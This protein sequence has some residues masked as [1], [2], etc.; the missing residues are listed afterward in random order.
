MARK[1]AIGLTV[2]ALVSG[3]ATYIAFTG[4]SP[5]GPNPQLVFIL[6]NLDLVLLLLLGAVVA[7][8]IVNLWVERRR[9]QAGSRLHIRLV[10]LFSIVAVTPAI[11]VAVFSA[12]FFNFGIQAWF[13]ERVRVALHESL[14]VTDAYLEEHTQTIRAD[15]LAMAN[16]INRDAPLLTRSTLIFQ[17]MVEEQAAARSMAEAIVF[18]GTGR[19]LASAGLSLALQLEPVP[20]FAMD[21]AR[22]GEVAIITSQDETRVRALVRLDRFFDTFLY[23]GRFI[24]PGVIAHVKRTQAAVAEY[25]RLEGQRSG[26]QISFFLLFAVVALLLL[27]A[28]VWV[29]LL[30]ANK[31]IGPIG[32]LI[33]AAERVGAGDLSARVNEIDTEDEIGG[34]SR[35]FN[36]MTA[37]LER[38]SQELVEANRQLDARRKFTETV[39]AGV[40]AGVIGL[41]AKGRINLPNRSAAELL[42]T[43]LETKIGQKLATAV[44]EM[45]DLLKRARR[46]PDRLHEAEVHLI[47]QGRTRTL[48]VRIAAERMGGEIIGFVVTFDDITELQS[49]QR[50]AAWADVARR[51]AH[52]IKNPLTPIQLSAERL[53]R[54]YLKEIKSEP[55]IFATCTD[56]IVRQVNDIGRMVDEFS[57]FARMPAPSMKPEDID[58]ICRQAVF[59]QSNAHPTIQFTTEFPDAPLN[60]PCDRRQISQAVTNLL[61]NA[62]DSITER[63]AQAPADDRPGRIALRV[64]VRDDAGIIEVEDNGQGLPA[65]LLPRLTEPYVT[66]RKKGTGLGL[67]IVRKIM[68]DHGGEVVLEDAEGGGA[69]VRLLFR[70]TELGARPEESE[71]S[72]TAKIIRTARTAIHG[73]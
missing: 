36:R 69:R 21:K 27:L 42:A 62:V 59:L 30:F 66:T 33:S 10:V 73:S 2:A 41:N 44:P 56:T 24:E 39:L 8:R 49:A 40:S 16:D 47:R 58:E 68:E 32:G 51:I 9:G 53:K 65:D 35:A 48:L 45:A 60:L 46:S 11:L 52:E 12:L 14:A 31:L 13:S 7:R 18:D 22:N 6:L 25:E 57:A 67:A 5:L 70:R 37:E 64:I 3:I 17:R 15:V 63:L 43:E 26:V 23:V 34:L 55:E 19:V 50:K 61:Q 1:L 71:P 28:A 54:K 29:G 4:S 72:G 20:D 38:H